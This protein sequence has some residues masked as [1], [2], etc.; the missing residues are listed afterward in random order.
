MPAGV[1]I[2][3]DDGRHEGG[4]MEGRR[5][6]KKVILKGRQTELILRCCRAISF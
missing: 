1:T 5:D 6:A 2:S 3:C 4:E